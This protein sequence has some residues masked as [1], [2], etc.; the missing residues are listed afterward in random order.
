MDGLVMDGQ[1]DRWMAN[2][3]TR[4]KL[5]LDPNHKSAPSSRRALPE[6]KSL[7]SCLYLV[8]TTPHL[9]LRCKSLTFV[10]IIKTLQLHGAVHAGHRRAVLWVGNDGDLIQASLEGAQQPD[11]HRSG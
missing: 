1:L 2:R 11:T 4:S 7:K 9:Y 10:R 8:R 6:F 5:Y 3:Q